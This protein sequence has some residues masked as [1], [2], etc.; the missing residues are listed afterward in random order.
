MKGKHYTS[1]PEFSEQNKNGCKM[2]QPKN[3]W[4]DQYLIPQCSRDSVAEN[5]GRMLK[6]TEER[7]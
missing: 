7:G 3:N 1:S 6:N 2:W 4:K 5:E